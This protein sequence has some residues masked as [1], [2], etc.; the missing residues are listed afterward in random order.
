MM[1]RTHLADALAKAGRKD[2]AMEVVRAGLQRTPD[3]PMLVRAL[4]AT[5]ESLG[6]MQDA[7]QAYRDYVRLS[8]NA[9][10][11]KGLSD[12]AAWLEKRAGSG[13]S[14]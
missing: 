9:P 14:S 12:R 2:E 5:L 1:A 13:S 6:R 8:P 4:G 11:A 10:D 3:Q 7:A